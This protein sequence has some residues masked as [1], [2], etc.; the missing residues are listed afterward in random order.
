[1]TFLL[2]TL[3]VA[4]AALCVWLIVRIINRRER[5]AKWTLA[6]V[7]G[8]PLLY[9]ASFGPACWWFSTPIKLS[10]IGIRARRAPEIYS[11]IGWSVRRLGTGNIQSFA[12]WYATA[13]IPEGEGVACGIREMGDP[14]IVFMAR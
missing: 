9:I 3:S 8:L 11:P 1:M 7:V 10:F 2:P 12:N 4:F 13:A 6:V 14:G 5:W